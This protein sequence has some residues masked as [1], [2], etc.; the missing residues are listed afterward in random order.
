V[1]GS[2]N[3]HG[4]AEEAELEEKRRRVAGLLDEQDLDALVLRRPGNV[5]WLSGGGRTHI[6]ATPDVGVADVVVRRDGVEVVTAVNEAPRLE[7]EELARL[8]ATVRAIPWSDADPGDRARHLPTGPRVGADAPLPGARLVQD[9]VR[10]LRRSLTPAELERYRALGRDTARAL[11]AVAQEL[12]PGESE[13]SAAARLGRALLAQGSD[14]VVL[15][16]AGGDRLRVHR[17]PL[18][19]PG[20]VGPRVMLVAC[21]RR[22]GL[23]ASITRFVAFGGLSEEDRDRFDRLLQVDVAFNRA[24]VAGATVGEACRAGVEAYETFGFGR[25]EW[26]LHHQGGPTGYEGRDLFAVPDSTPIIAEDQAFAWNPSIEGLKSEDTIVVQGSTP[27][28]L[29]VDA[30]WPTL[31]VEGLARPLVLER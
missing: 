31:D 8:G 20:P 12:D 7:S 5:A 9:E 26:L 22:H 16:V 13:F 29:T 4:P 15:L 6:L 11:T 24:T 1:T 3:G 27:E 21:A 10:A 23:I 19:T 18:P 25:D 28:I 30:A 14:P 17:H 2:G